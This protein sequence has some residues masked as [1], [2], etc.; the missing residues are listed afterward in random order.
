M[1]SFVYAETETFP[2]FFF[3]RFPDKHLRSK[4]QPN[5]GLAHSSVVEKCPAAFLTVA[6]G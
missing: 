1:W 3:L 5:H 6:A 2:I 4:S